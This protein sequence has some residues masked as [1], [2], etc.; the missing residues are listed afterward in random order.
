MG[1]STIVLMV[2]NIGSQV[3]AQESTKTSGELTRGDKDNISIELKLG[4]MVQGRIAV[5]NEM[6]AVSIVGPDGKQVQRFGQTALGD[7]YYAATTDGQHSIVVEHPGGP[8]DTRGYN[9]EYSILPTVLAPGTG[10]GTAPT[11]IVSSL[12][13]TFLVIVGIV[14]LFFILRT[15]YR[16]RSVPSEVAY[17][18]VTYETELELDEYYSYLPLYGEG[19][20]GM[21]TSEFASIL[22]IETSQALRILMNW[23]KRGIVRKMPTGNEYK[24]WRTLD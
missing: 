23:Q 9:M 24:W 2:L 8:A 12:L 18:P 1:L 15:L 4:E 20:M 14:A 10:S 17:E 5:H 19:E 3:L 6:L 11:G 7:F 21:L 16:R 13:T 22:G